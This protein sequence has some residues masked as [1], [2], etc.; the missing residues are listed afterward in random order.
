MTPL[1]TLTASYLTSDSVVGVFLS[2]SRAGGVADDASDVDLVVLTD[3]PVPQRWREE[4]A[5]SQRPERLDLAPGHFGDG[6]AWVA[7]GIAY[8]VMFWDLRWITDELTAVIRDHRVSEGYTTAHWYSVATWEKLAGNPAYRVELDDLA[9]LAATD[10]PD[11]LAR[12]IIDHNYSLLGQ[13]IFSYLAQLDKAV[14]RGDVVSVQHRSAAI[15]AS[16]A[17]CVFAH[18]RRLHPGE[19]KLLTHAAAL[20]SLPEAAITDVSA[21]AA[22]DTARASLLVERLGTWLERGAPNE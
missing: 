17:D 4:I 10:Y 14:Q 8:D 5:L 19:K 11:E 22:G 18:H 6:D 12:R 16:W 1:D 20:G 2:G 7:G 13:V 9:A 3:G 21:L 15:I